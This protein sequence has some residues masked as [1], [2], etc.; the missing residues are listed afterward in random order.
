MMMMMMMGRLERVEMSDWGLDPGV[1]RCE[2]GS[3][4]VLQPQAP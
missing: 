1:P 3:K 2:D 4:K